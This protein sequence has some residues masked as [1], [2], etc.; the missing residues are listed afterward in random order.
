M[1]LLE[2]PSVG[3]IGSSSEVR[4]DT[5]ITVSPLVTT[6][7]TTASK[8]SSNNTP[9][10]QKSSN[11]VSKQK[12]YGRIWLQTIFN[13][14]CHRKVT[15]HWKYLLLRIIRLMKMTTMQIFQ[16]MHPSKCI[17]VHTSHWRRCSRIISSRSF[18]KMWSFTKVWHNS[19]FES[20]NLTRLYK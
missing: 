6:N 17:S 2:F 3:K 9:C 4:T 16:Y 20:K 19:N 10:Y 1:F 7:L 12:K 18:C 11:W 15:S 5:H 13:G 14:A 8:K